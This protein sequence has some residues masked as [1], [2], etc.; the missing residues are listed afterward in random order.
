MRL[1]WFRGV[2]SA[3][4]ETLLQLF[5]SQNYLGN[6]VISGALVDK[7]NVEEYN[8]NLPE[9]ISGLYCVFRRKSLTALSRHFST[10]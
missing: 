9:I 7:C 10:V 8:W 4:L 6:L 2:L 1:P 3:Y 5:M